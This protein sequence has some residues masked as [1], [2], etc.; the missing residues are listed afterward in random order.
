MVKT[1]R[2]LRSLYDV[3]QESKRVSGSNIDCIQKVYKAC[4][5]KFRCI[6][7][8]VIYYIS[9]DSLNQFLVFTG[10]FHFMIYELLLYE[11][12]VP[13]KSDPPLATVISSLKRWQSH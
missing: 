9:N 3:K 5:R 2:V 11:C 10:T 7:E 13:V 12:A 6:K 8:E 4:K 1:T